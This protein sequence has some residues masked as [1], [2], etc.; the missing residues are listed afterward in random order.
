MSK[1]ISVI[2]LQKFLNRRKKQKFWE[3]RFPKYGFP[4]PWEWDAFPSPEARKRELEIFKELQGL[5]EKK[6]SNESK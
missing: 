3:Y 6:R 2:S 5:T 1:F 4:P